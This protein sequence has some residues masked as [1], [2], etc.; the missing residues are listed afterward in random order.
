MTL[1]LDASV[2]LKWYVP[3]EDADLADDICGRDRS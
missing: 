1:V 2:T 3:E